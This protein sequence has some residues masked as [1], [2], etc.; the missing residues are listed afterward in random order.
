MKYTPGETVRNNSVKIKLTVLKSNYTAGENK[1][2]L[3][4]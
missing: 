3:H 1:L 4:M 2:Q